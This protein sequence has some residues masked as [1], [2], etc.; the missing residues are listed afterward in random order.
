MCKRKLLGL[1]IPTL[2]WTAAAIAEEDGR[3][4]GRVTRDGTGLAGVRVTLEAPAASRLTDEEGRYAFGGLTP[5]VYTLRFAFGDHDARDEVRVDPGEIRR[6]ETA[7]DWQLSFAEAITVRSASRHRERIVEAPAAVT[8]LSGEEIERNASHGQLPKL[9]EFTPGVEIVQSGV[10]YFNLNTRA[11]N[12]AMN[13][14]VLTLIDGR[15]PS[16]PVTGNQE[17]AA[18]AFPLDDIAN[19]ELVR[20][21][22]SALYGA[23]AFNGVLN[24]TTRAPRDSQGG[25]ARFTFGELATRRFDLRQAAELGGGWYLK[26]LAGYTESDD[27]A[28]SRNAGVEYSSP[29]PDFSTFDCLPLE[30]IP[31]VQDKNVIKN[32]SLRLDRALGDDLL[33]VEAGQAEPEGVIPVTQVGRFQLVAVERPWARLRY[34]AP[35]WNAQ[36]SYTG[37]E[38]TPL[39]LI[40][41]VEQVL[42][43]DRLNLEAQADADFADGRGMLVVGASYTEEDV[44]SADSSGRQTLLVSRREEDYQGI[45]GQ[46]EYDLHDRLKGVF[47]ARWDDSSIHDA[48][49]SPRA[50]LVFAAAPDH[51]LRLT[52]A[53]AFQTPVYSELFAFIEV[54]PPIDL[55]PL[56]GICA[57]GG[58]VCGFGQP[59]P[60]VTVGNED[61]EV[62]E[63]DALEL[64][65]AGIF[66]DR[67][68]VTVDLYEHR[69]ESFLTEPIDF[70]NAT[71]GRT[72][73]DNYPPYRPPDDLA[74]PLAALLTGTL[75]ALLPPELFAILTS[76]P[77]NGAPLFT[78]LS[79]TNF[80]RVDSRGLDFG[81]S[82][83]LGERWTLDATYSRYDFEVR[84]Q[85]PEDPVVPNS[86]E[87]RFA[88]GLAYVG[89]RLDA[90]LR[91]RHSDSFDWKSGL[92][93]GR[94]PAYDVVDLTANFEVRERLRLGVDVSNLFDDEHYEI[95]GGDLIGRRALA[96]VTL[97][98]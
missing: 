74:P 58:T 6:V 83:Y 47:A 24:I 85:L 18:L 88:L 35:R 78:A 26:L 23:D 96:S 72:I 27:F 98:W 73:N 40:N 42:D 97:L 87:D 29:C 37:R 54:A 62:E 81:L 61:L 95:F 7:V 91:Y 12:Q 45:F 16:V 63:I 10:Y 69:M 53:Q 60:V 43:S 1:L 84:D 76:D 15:D 49:F 68:F 2:L 65:Y 28:R 30:A 4:E 20:G 92:Y 86:A 82:C 67:L 14:R 57:L 21:P 70:F 13:R 9:L 31:R 32:A 38:D 41:G 64:G 39:Q 33:T 11:P 48:R 25:T 80:A 89:D 56:E 94:V 93:R 75:Q 46:V 77:R 79:H 66:G 3:I 8:Y 19:L 50:S 52:W 5:G 59:V 55:S 22:G 44:D 51:T 71:L 34:S 90:A 36:A 17:W